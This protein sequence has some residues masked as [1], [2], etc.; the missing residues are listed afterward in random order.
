MRL[1]GIT[2][3][4][5]LAAATACTPADPEAAVRNFLDE[6]AAAAESRNTA[7]FRAH[8]DAAYTDARGRNR[9]DVIALLRGYFLVNTNVEVISRVQKIELDGEDFADVVVQVAAVANRGGGPLD[10][11]AGLRT[12]E[13]ELARDGST[14]KVIR[15]NWYR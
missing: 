3:A 14:W 10:L 6:A 7:F 4:V 13:L 5:A 8:V 11:D 2:A 9:D 1:T 12:M 15:A